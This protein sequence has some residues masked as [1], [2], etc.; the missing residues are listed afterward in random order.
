MV[1]GPCAGQIGPHERRRDA[2]GAEQVAER[3]RVLRPRPHDPHRQ[4]VLQVLADGQV[5]ERLDAVRLQMLGRADARQ[6][7]Q[8]RRVERAAGQ[9]H[10]AVGV[11]GLG[12]AALLVLDAGRARALHQHA[13]REGVW[14]RPSRLARPRAGMQ[15]GD[16]GRA[17]AAV[18]DR[19]LRAREAE[20]LLAV[21]VVVDGVAG[22]A[23]RHRAS[24]PTSDRARGRR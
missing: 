17:A 2:V 9:D 10:L 24:R 18:L 3:A 4:M 21:E 19:V 7:Q 15:E 13:G 12:L 1:A 8:L 22:V 16:G 5:D 6:H 11:R 20:L 14:S 23:W